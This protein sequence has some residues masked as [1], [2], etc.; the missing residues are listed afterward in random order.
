MLG[1]KLTFIF[2][3]HPTFSGTPE[4]KAERFSSSVVL[5]ESVKSIEDLK[6]RIL[7]IANHMAYFT[8]Y[9]LFVNCPDVDLRN[10]PVAER[11]RASLHESMNAICFSFDGI[12]KRPSQRKTLQL[13]LYAPARFP[14]RHI[15]VFSLRSFAAQSDLE[16][17]YITHIKGIVEPLLALLKNNGDEWYCLQIDPRQWQKRQAQRFNRINAKHRRETAAA[18]KRAQRLADKIAAQ[19]VKAETSGS[20]GPSEH[21]TGRVPGARPGIYR[22]VQMRS[23]LEINFAADLD[24]RGIKWVYEGEALGQA[25]YLVDFY[26]PDLG[27]WIEVK[28]RMTPKDRQVLP[29]VARVLKSERQQKLLMYTGSGPCLVVNPSGFREIERKQFWTE[30]IR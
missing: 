29:D 17:E 20:T 25:Q 12:I 27:V 28:G 4:A 23:Q 7:E 16:V 5:P 19:T 1:V 26:L 21:G 8:N 22:G 30:V 6:A 15:T 13:H 9:S 14:S 2:T 11:N 18:E 24:E 3:P 10:Y